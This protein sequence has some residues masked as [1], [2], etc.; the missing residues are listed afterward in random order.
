[1]CRHST[2]CF[3]WTVPVPSL[4][5]GHMKKMRLVRTDSPRSRKLK[6]N[7]EQCIDLTSAQSLRIAFSLQCRYVCVVVCEALTYV[8]SDR[9]VRATAHCALHGFAVI[10]IQERPNGSCSVGG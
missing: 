2:F 9:I 1:M 10:R 5:Y 7:G 4:Q 3:Q 8:T 6:K